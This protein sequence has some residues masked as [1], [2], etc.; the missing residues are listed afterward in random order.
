[1]QEAEIRVG[2]LAARSGVTVDTVRYYERQRLLPR[3]H[4]TEGNFRLFPLAA[5]ECIKFIKGAQSLGFSLTE[6]SDLMEPKERGVEECQ[7]MYTL[8][9]ERIQELDERF[10]AMKEFRSRLVG[11]VETCKRTLEG[12]GKITEC[13]V[14]LEIVRGNCALCK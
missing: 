5:V 1:M 12:P 8:L 9:C 10:V 2:V 3:A 11:H 13:P 6:I 7:Q 4:R 14:R